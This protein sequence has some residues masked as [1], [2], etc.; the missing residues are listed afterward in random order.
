MRT[1]YII[2]LFCS[3]L[4]L[5]LAAGSSP[6]AAGN[7]GSRSSA[8][9]QNHETP[10]DPTGLGGSGTS[11]SGTQ[12]PNSGYPAVSTEN[13][14]GT[15]E[16]APQNTKPKEKPQKGSLPGTSQGMVDPESHGSTDPASHRHGSDPPHPDGDD[17]TTTS[18]GRGTSKA[19]TK[20]STNTEAATIDATKTT[21]ATSAIPAPTTNPT[22]TNDRSPVVTP[23]QSS[24]R[25]ASGAGFTETAGV[26][27]LLG[28]LVAVGM[29][30]SAF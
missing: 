28:L 6:P 11:E 10:R 17:P 24:V 5:T 13:I 18:S 23:G 15:D 21:I 19:Y 27:S 25:G 8:P 9:K 20:P 14:P 22:P 3:L 7:A 16:H 4:T 2:L 29:G 1:P 12:Y 30:T 26:Y